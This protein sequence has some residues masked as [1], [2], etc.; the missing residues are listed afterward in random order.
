MT[1]SAS[2]RNALLAGVVTLASASSAFADK[3]AEFGFLIVDMLPL[4]EG[5]T[6]EEVYAYFAAVEPIFAKY[7]LVRT[8]DALEVVNIARGKVQAQVINL[9]ATKDPKIAFDG[10]FTDPEYLKHVENRDSIFDLKNANVVVTRRNAAD[11][12]EIAGV[13]H[14]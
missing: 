2:L 11:T 8:D 1:R 9:W 7:D 14:P 6:L 4:H 12:P 10:I 3:A 5:A 13:S